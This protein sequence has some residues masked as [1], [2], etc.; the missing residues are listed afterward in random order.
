MTKNSKKQTATQ[1]IFAAYTKYISELVL[2][3]YGPSYSTQEEMRNSWRHK[4]QYSSEIENFLIFKTQMFIRFLDS[5]DSNSTNPQVLDALTREI[6]DYLSAY[7][8][9]VPNVPTRKKAKTILKHTLYDNSSYIRYLLINQEL[10][11]NDRD[12][13]RKRYVNAK[14]CVRDF[15]HTKSDTVRDVIEIVIRKR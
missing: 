12:K 5:R 7:T 15:E 9:R 8:M 14:R 1:R 2:D 3:K 10:K 6:A 4:I 13:R 11:R